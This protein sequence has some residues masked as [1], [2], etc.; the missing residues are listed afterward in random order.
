MGSRVSPKRAPRKCRGRRRIR[1][2][3]RINCVEISWAPYLATWGIVLFSSNTLLTV[4]WTIPNWSHR[5][6]MDINSDKTDH[7]SISDASLSFKHHIKS[8]LMINCIINWESDATIKKISG[9]E[10]DRSLST[11]QKSLLKTVGDQEKRLKN[12]KNDTITHAAEILGLQEEWVPAGTF[13][14]FVWLTAY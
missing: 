8:L 10:M 6:T 12:Y 13:T 1:S 7:S 11:A 4:V 2:W 9:S 3:S 5:V 14:Y